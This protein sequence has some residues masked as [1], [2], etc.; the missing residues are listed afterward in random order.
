L[1]SLVSDSFARKSVATAT[2][3]ILGVETYAGFT[4][5][6]P[7][8]RRLK[9]LLEPIEIVLIGTESFD[10]LLGRKID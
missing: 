7:L 2:L 9:F 10:A 1:G 5:I 6:E 8:E 3:Y 4:S